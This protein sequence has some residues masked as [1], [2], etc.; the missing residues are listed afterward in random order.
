MS[1]HRMR[2]VSGSMRFSQVLVLGGAL[3]VTLLLVASPVFGAFSSNT[4]S[5]LAAPQAPSLS[6]ASVES[7]VPAAAPAPAANVSQPPCYKIDTT[8]CVSMLNVNETNII[9]PSG[10][11]SSTQEPNASGDLILAVK[12]HTRL[13]WPNAPHAGPISPV[14]LNVTANLWN[15]DS[16]YTGN[17]GTIWHA[18]SATVWWTALPYQSSNLTYPWWYTVTFFAHGSGGAPNFY[19]GMSVYWWIYLT[20][21]SSSNPS[22]PYSHPKPIVFH[23]T[24]S[25]AWPFSPYPGAGGYVGSSATFED[26]NLT[27]TPRAPNFNDSVTMLLN[28]TQADVLSNA[29]I[30]ANSYVDVSEVSPNGSVVQSGTFLFPVTVQGGFGAVSSRV[31]IPPAYSQIAGAVVT[32][33]LSVRDVANDLLVTPPASYT[34]GGNGSFLSGIF[35]DDLELLTNPGAVAAEPVGTVMLNPGAPLALTLLSRNPGTSISAAQVAYTL[36]YPLLHESLGL[37]VPFTRITSTDFV[38]QIPGL[39][40]G[41]FLNFTV[42]AWDFSERLEVSPELGYFTPDLQTQIPQIPGNASFF[43]VYVYDNGSSHW[44]TGAKVQIQGFGGVYNSITNTTAGVAYPNLTFAPF[45]PLLLVANS[46]Y[47]VTVSDP[48]FVSPTE[49]TG[50]SVNVSVLALHSMTARQT[51]QTGA[52]YSVVQEGNAI[53]FWLNATLPPPAASPSNGGGNVPLGA[54]L[55]IVGATVIMFPLV[56]WFRQIRA[57][58]KAEERRVTL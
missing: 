44:V 14:A 28:T 13:D 57:R 8:V 3:V 15:G 24:Y 10:S 25:G 23:F 7:G 21:N 51:L 56:L 26:I 41:S 30:G 35:P 29:T 34:V 12:S 47:H 2:R 40:I 53:V 46:T 31:V 52:D 49:G 33:V 54:V 6:R 1:L 4:R 42:Q 27:V 37:T 16:Y 20:Y 5:V 45:T 17:D 58:R 38:A 11:Y 9:P 43:F 19:P 48:F 39:P 36:N 18:N 32:Y 22:N 55:G 50:G